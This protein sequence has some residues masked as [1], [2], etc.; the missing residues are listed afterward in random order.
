[1]QNITGYVGIV[2][3]Q[4]ILEQ[5]CDCLVGLFGFGLPNGLQRLATEGAGKYAQLL[6]A[7]LGCFVEQ[8]VAGLEGCLDQTQA[9]LSVFQALNVISR[10]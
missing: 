4:A 6:E 10:R 7:H 8:V 1:M 2:I 9:G 5:L 3:E